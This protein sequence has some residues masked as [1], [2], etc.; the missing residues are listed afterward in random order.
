MT[1]RGD[2]HLPTCTCSA[3]NLARSESLE[4]RALKWLRGLVIDLF[5]PPRSM[6]WTRVLALT[7]V[8]AV[9]MLGLLLAWIL[10]IALVGIAFWG[11]MFGLLLLLSYWWLNIPVAGMTYVDALIRRSKRPQD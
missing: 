6:E 1:D 11:L 4:A 2:R 9:M 5:R 8:G 7:A 3:C 10:L